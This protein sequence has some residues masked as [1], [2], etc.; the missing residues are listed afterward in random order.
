[1]AF[2]RQ[3]IPHYRAVTP[4]RVWY[5]S[6]GRSKNL[7]TTQVEMLGTVPS[8]AAQVAD[9]L[10]AR[11]FRGHDVDVVTRHGTKICVA[12]AGD[13][14]HTIASE[15]RQRSSHGPVLPPSSPAPRRPAPA[16]RAPA[17]RRPASSVAGAPPRPSTRCRRR[18]PEGGRAPELPTPVLRARR[19]PRVHPR[20][21]A[22]SP[23][24]QPSPVPDASRRPDGTAPRCRCTRSAMRSDLQRARR[25]RTAR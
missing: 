8:G 24:A 9:S 1:M 15:N 11:H 20:S 14:R 2:A 25:A 12:P 17:P 6:G 21:P 7:P 16:W 13:H 22:R 3:H 18:A 4:Q 10:G 19:R 5:V 23:E